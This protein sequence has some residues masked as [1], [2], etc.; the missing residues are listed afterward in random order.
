VPASRCIEAPLLGK[1]DFQ[2][3]EKQHIALLHV[4]VKFLTHLAIF[5]CHYLILFWIFFSTHKKTMAGKLQHDRCKSYVGSGL[6]AIPN[7]YF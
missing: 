4:Y 3:D 1:V 7:Q 5:C 2:V 6:V